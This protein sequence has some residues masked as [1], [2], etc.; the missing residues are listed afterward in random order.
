M[1]RIPPLRASYRWRRASAIAALAL[2][3][4]T[5]SAAQPSAADKET[6][7]TLIGEGQKKFNA[8]DYQGALISWKGADDI[9]KVPTTGLRVGKAYEKV[10][11]LV[12]ALDVWLRVMRSQP[13]P[14][15]SKLFAKAR[16][17]AKGLA[18]AVTKRIPS[19]K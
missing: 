6:A 1:H 8:E 15:E 5:V 13:K 10:G 16:E 7:R 14:G 4:T 18:A 11:K 2:L 17:E 12:E 19:V 9:M 3:V